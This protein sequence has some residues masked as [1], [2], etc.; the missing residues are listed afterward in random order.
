MKIVTGVAV[1]F[2]LFFGSG[3]LI[4][5][6]PLFRTGTE[7][8]FSGEVD[9]K[10]D[11]KQKFISAFKVNDVIRNGQN[12]FCNTTMSYL[13][14]QSTEPESYLFQFAC[15]TVNFYV[16]SANFC[17]RKISDVEKGNDGTTG[18][19]VVYPL[20]MKIGDTLPD[21][22][23][24]SVDH[25]PEGSSVTNMRFTDRVVVAIDTLKL[26]FALTPAYRITSKRSS[27][28]TGTSKYSGHFDN[29]LEVQLTEWFTPALGVVKV[30]ETGETSVSRGVLESYSEH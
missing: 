3:D 8:R 16:I 1:S 12:W 13:F 22:W 27:G 5:P 18:D 21:A 26:S 19:S 10:K 2:T 23:C 25:F 17:Y 15:D 9:G 4:R 14:D 6:E 7:Y 24:R 28:I 29:K 11:R 20:R 30:E